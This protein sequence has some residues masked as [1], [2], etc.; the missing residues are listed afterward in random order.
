MPA[1]ALLKNAF[2]NAVA[3]S[4]Y[5]DIQ[6]RRSNYFYYLGKT[7]SWDDELS[8]DVPIDSFNYERSIRSEIITAKLIKPTDISYVVPRHNWSLDEAG[9]GRVYDQYDDQY[10]TSL[11]GIDLISSGIGYSVVPKVY[12]GSSGS[13]N[14]TPN[15][16]FEV[17]SLIKV[18]TNTNVLYFTVKIPGIASDI[19]P[20]HT[21]GDEYNGT[22]LL[23]AV[24]IS[25]GG[26]TGATAE[27]VISTGKVT[28]I[29]IIKS[30]SGYTSPPSVLIVGNCVTS[31]NAE[32]VIVKGSSTGAQKI[33]DARFYV[34]TNDYKVYKCLDNNNGGKSTVKPVDISANAV[35]YEDGYI[36]KFMY[37]IPASLRNKF[38]TNLYMP[39]VN[40]QQNQYYDSGEIRLVRI[41]SPGINYST[42]KINVS[43]DGY[44]ESDPL[45]ITNA[46]IVSGGSNYTDP[47]ITFESPFDDVNSWSEAPSQGAPAPWLPG[48][49]VIT[50]QRYSY[51]DNIYEVIVAGVFSSVGPTHTQG[52][53]ENGDAVLKYVGTTITGSVFADE[54]GVITEIVLNG[55]IKSIDIISEGSGYSESPIVTIGDGTNGASAKA[56]IQNQ[57][58][59]Y[60]E[61][62]DVGSNFTNAP[63]IVIGNEWEPEKVVAIG[64]QVFYGYN[65]YTVMNDGVLGNTPPTHSTLDEEVSDG[66]IILKYVG[67]A[68]KAAASLKY[69]AGYSV[70]PQIFIDGFVKWV[71]AS[72][73][74]IGDK[75][76]FG[77]NRYEVVEEGVTGDVGPIHSE[78]VMLNGTAQLEWV[79]LQ[80][81]IS[82]SKVK[83]EALLYPIIENKQIV[84]VNVLNPGIGYT[85]ATLDVVGNEGSYGAKLYTDLS[86]GDIN[87]LQSNVELLTVDGQI[88]CIPVV[89]GGYGYDDN[90]LGQQYSSNTVVEIFG[91]GIGA[92]ALASVE[93][94]RVTKIHVV[95]P[96][97]GYRQASIRILGNGFGATARAIISPYKGHGSN[98]VN[99]L[100]AKTLVFF[101]NIS[102][103]KNQGFDVNNDYRQIGIIKSPRRYNSANMLTSTVASGCWAVEGNIVANLFPPDSLLTLTVNN[104]NYKFRVVSLKTTDA[105]IFARALDGELPF[106]GDILIDIFGS[107]YLVTY[108]NESTLEISVQLLPG[109]IIPAIETV[110][111]DSSENTYEV[112]AINQPSTSALIQSLDN[113]TLETGSVLS[114]ENGDSFIISKTTSPT[115]DKYSGSL[116]FVDNRLAFTPT[117]EQIVTLRTLI[118]F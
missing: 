115:I 5:N 90:D 117:T 6:Y 14:W 49:S 43:G 31:A 42:A 99:E 73:V 107:E 83:S 71:A 102:T 113:I 12:I 56:I 110:M 19:A 89:S 65:L 47:V 40:A 15:A 64:D 36:W 78:G 25:D 53:V 52:S 69:G 85:Y 48:L 77:N 55:K 66:N 97:S 34:L 27:A 94:G 1:L 21:V 10:D 116:M 50:G 32:A 92:T 109:G 106:I 67:Q 17:D 54:N 11:H 68:A 24:T 16:S 51:N 29:N 70:I 82:L 96:G 35:Q 81:D 30:G 105:V 45:Y 75:I 100:F 2:H 18:V 60:I 39:V 4:V 38:L 72:N 62:I 93:G 61:V 114:N 28:S 87:S 104:Y 33:E 9:N 74:S 7:L 57:S 84:G 26:G 58:V 46:D 63:I 59:I 86:F 108:I 103:D 13:V 101:T 95:N 118:D 23:S 22:C 37:A 44:I 91:D 111:S 98:A 8:P 79:G 76:Y 20:S 80:A 112:T 41:E 88:N 3:E